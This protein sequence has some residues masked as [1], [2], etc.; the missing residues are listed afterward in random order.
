MS[1]L[2]SS[3]TCRSPPRSPSTARCWPSTGQPGFSAT[4]PATPGATTSKVTN[5][6][7]TSSWHRPPPHGSALRPLPADPARSPQPPPALWLPGR[8]P[9]GA[10][11]LH[12][13][14]SDRATPLCLPTRPHFVYPGDLTLFTR[15]TPLCLPGRL[16]SHFG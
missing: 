6:F 7:R 5:P 13:H 11:R 9:P 14:F 10:P 3:P 1:C 2:R 12:P 15:A 16:H 4:T 8:L